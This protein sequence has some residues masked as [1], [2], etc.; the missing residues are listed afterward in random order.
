LSRWDINGSTTVKH[1]CPD[2]L[3][4]ALSVREQVAPRKFRSIDLVELDQGIA[5]ILETDAGVE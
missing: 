4:Y 3:H 5:D 1:I 2:L